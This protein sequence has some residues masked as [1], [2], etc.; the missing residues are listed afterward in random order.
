MKSTRKMILHLMFN[1]YMVHSIDVKTLSINML[2]KQNH[3]K[4]FYQNNLA[5]ERF[6]F[7]KFP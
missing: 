5:T 7:Q 1:E 2:A 4:E 3:S 6:N